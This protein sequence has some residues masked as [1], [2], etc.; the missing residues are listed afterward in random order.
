[1]I[2]RLHRLN[3]SRKGA[4]DRRQKTED[5]GQVGNGVKIREELK[6]IVPEY[7]PEG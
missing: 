7:K 4:K 5:G 1:M 6:R 3:L 2:R